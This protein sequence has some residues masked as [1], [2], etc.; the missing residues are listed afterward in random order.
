MQCNAE[1]AR[2][3]GFHSQLSHFSPLMILWQRARAEEMPSY[4]ADSHEPGAA[5][6]IKTFQLKTFP[7]FRRVSRGARE[8]N[9]VVGEQRGALAVLGDNLA[10]LEG[11]LAKG[12]GDRHEEQ[13]GHDGEGED[14]LEGNHLGEEL[15]H[16]ESYCRRLRLAKVSAERLSTEGIRTGSQDAQLKAHGVVLV[17]GDEEHAV[18]QDGP[19]E[20]VAEDTGNQGC[21]VG[22]HDGTIPVDGDKSPR[23]RH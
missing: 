20:D 14:P 7:L 23:K 17:D 9:L 8:K 16:A 10:A 19:D 18:G 3:N 6:M 11:V 4:M 22:H 1:V 21:G 5:H 15:G 13:D 2:P 12:D